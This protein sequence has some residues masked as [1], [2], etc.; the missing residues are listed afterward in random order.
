MLW[1]RFIGELPVVRDVNFLLRKEGRF[2]IPRLEEVKPYINFD[3]IPTE[4]TTL[5]LKD[6]AL[7][8]AEE[9]LHKLPKAAVLWSGGA[10]ST[11]AL[12][13][14]NEVAGRP[15]D[16]LVTDST[17]Q[18]ADP[19]FFKHLED[20]GTQVSS[21]RLFDLQRYVIDGGTFI[22]GTHGDNLCLSDAV[23][24]ASVGFADRI[25]DMTVPQLLEE[26]TGM[27]NGDNLWDRFGYLFDRMPAHIPRDAPNC[28]WWIGFC[29]YWPRDA[30]YMGVQSGLG[31]P[32][33]THEHFF[34]SQAFQQYMIEPV[35][36]RVGKSVATHK[37]RVIE[38]IRD[39]L[40]QEIFVHQK[41]A[42][43]E[44]VLGDADLSQVDKVDDEFNIR[45]RKI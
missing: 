20:M 14:L 40:G 10:D 4:R 3:P 5:S 36:T 34:S 27:K 41:T 28:L 8:R 1:N 43:W 2:M 21:G 9:V 26:K 39:I 19:A 42:G 44:E 16:V 7:Q 31:Q 13:A 25:W 18:H 23:E 6:I 29:F 35:E 11:L 30:I 24:A 17:Y 45:W 15:V 38:A 22:T 12:V 37:D 32:G 33:V